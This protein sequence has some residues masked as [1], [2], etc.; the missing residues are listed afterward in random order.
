LA[1]IL[2]PP[3][4]GNDD[5]SVHLGLTRPEKRK[6]TSDQTDINPLAV[7]VRDLSHERNDQRLWWD[8]D[9]DKSALTPVVF[10]SCI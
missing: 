5:N 1:H 4:A 9:Q 2:L 8:Y 6:L 3:T 7:P 10:D